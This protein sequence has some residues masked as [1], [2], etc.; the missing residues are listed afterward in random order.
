MF[1]GTGEDLLMA[2]SLLFA[3]G[4]PAG[5][6]SIQAEWLSG[7]PLGDRVANLSG[8][9]VGPR[10]N[11]NYFLIPG[12]T[13][14]DDAAVDVVFGEGEDDWIVANLTEDL[15]SD[16]SVGDLTLDLL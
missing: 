6:Y 9:G 7:R 13:A 12:S 8:A 14:N 15:V 3:G 10:N 16:L 1:G 4:L 2:G 5:V 11:G